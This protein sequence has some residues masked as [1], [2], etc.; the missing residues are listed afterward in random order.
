MA[1]DRPQP[2][3]ATIGDRWIAAG[4][5]MLC[6]VLYLLTAAPTL[7]TYDSAEFA[8]GV[9]TL[10]IVHAP[11]YPLYT[12]LAHGFT[13]LPIGDLAYRVNV[14]SAVC[15][16]LAAPCLYLTMRTLK[17]SRAAAA[18]ATLCLMA[19]FYVWSSGIR[20][21]I[22]APQ[23]LTVAALCYGLA[24]LAVR[25]DWPRGAPYGLAVVFGI[26]VAMHPI[27]ALF[28]G[29]LVLLLLSRKLAWRTRVLAGALSVAVFAV[30]LLY[31]VWRGPAAPALNLAGRYDAQGQFQPVDLTT[32]QGLFW[33]LRGE[34]FE[35]LFQPFP[36]L[37]Q[38]QGTATYFW[39]NF[40]GVGVA[41]G[42]IGLVVMPN[43]LRLGWLVLF[44]PFTYFYTSYA[45]VDRDTML[46]P[47]FLLWAVLIGYGFDYVFNPQTAP[48]VLRLGVLALLPLG[49][50][51]VNFPRL[52]LS[53]DTHV[54]QRAQ[55]TLDALPP[56]SI[57]IGDWFDVVPLQYLWIVEGQRPDVRMYN[58]FLFE[59]EDL[60]DYIASQPQVIYLGTNLNPA[61]LSPGYSVRALTLDIPT[62]EH[63]NEL[64]PTVAA[65]IISR[66]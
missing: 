39:Q 49:V 58:S 29:G 47:S 38:L 55:I 34:Q 27:N 18:S 48:R 59:F 1:A 65:Y 13:A 6:A 17:H 36:T 37:P 63:P 52:N 8:I 4:V 33:L 66:R 5:A 25:T 45:A 28:G 62:L 26:T 64:R 53:T 3:P 2:S 46:G 22:Y 32:P 30:P 31:F 54:R 24:W 41:F 11:G 35:N 9:A 14:F 20:A 57:V 60:R 16:A 21:E 61:L 12:L 7:Y 50:V 56:N 23:L 10:G 42:V 19:S 44:L 15:L 40:L 43:P 51:V